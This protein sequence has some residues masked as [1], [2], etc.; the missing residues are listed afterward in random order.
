MVMVFAHLRD[1]AL[2]ALGAGDA[3]VAFMRLA[4]HREASHAS[5]FIG[6][7]HKFVVSQT[8]RS[9]SESYEQQ[10]GQQG[11]EQRGRGDSL[12]PNFGRTI[13]ENMSESTGWQ[14][15]SSHGGL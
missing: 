15:G 4:D 10:R 9:R 12:G 11:G 5:N 14:S 3:A 2:D 7:E 13:S 6:R 1:D 8:T